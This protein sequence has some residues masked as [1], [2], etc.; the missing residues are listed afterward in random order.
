MAWHDSAWHGGSCMNA[1]RIMHAS[2][3]TDDHTRIK[4]GIPCVTAG[5]A[6]MIADYACVH[7]CMF[8]LHATIDT[9]GA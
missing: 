4:F 6:G 1:S 7:A 5:R 2:T 3:P 8:G 9:H